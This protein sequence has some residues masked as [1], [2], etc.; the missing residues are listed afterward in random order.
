[1]YLREFITKTQI[2]TKDY[3]RFTFINLHTQ[4]FEYT[5]LVDN[6]IV[7]IKENVLVEHGFNSPFERVEV[8]N[9]DVQVPSNIPPSDST[10]SKVIKLSYKL[11]V[12]AF[13]S[14]FPG[15]IKIGKLQVHGHIDNA[16]RRDVFL[17][18]PITIGT[19][20]LRF[21]RA[22]ELRPL[23]AQL[24]DT[25]YSSESLLISDANPSGELGI[26]GV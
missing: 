15:V 22:D 5:D 8:Y 14:I 12:S 3:Q 19:V 26:I 4:F 13:P 10:S 9:V 20:P 2:F 24:Q 23:T 1:M 7:K 18:I 16:C 17:E 25:D 6:D 11:R 21:A